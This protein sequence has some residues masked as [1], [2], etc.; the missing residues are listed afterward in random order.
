MKT[1]VLCGVDE[2]AD[3]VMS[4]ATS[5]S[6][7][8]F[9]TA[10]VVGL[11][12]CSPLLAQVETD[13]TRE[14][15]LEL[16]RELREIREQV[17]DR[18]E[19]IESRLAQ[20]ETSPEPLDEPDENDAPLDLEELLEEA[21]ATLS[22]TAPAE[23]NATPPPAAASTLNPRIS[24]IGDFLGAA[25]WNTP[26]PFAPPPLDVREVEI[27]FQSVIDP[28]AR[29]DFYV[30]VPSLEDVGLEE[31]FITF[32]TLPADLLVRLGKVR[33]PFGRENVDHRPE[34]FTVDR[35]DVIRAYF[36]DEGLSE[37]GVTLARLIPNPWDTFMELELDV[38]QGA[39]QESFGGGSVEDLLYNLRFRSYYDLNPRNNLDIG[40]SY[41]NGV[42][43]VV[44]ENRFRSQLFG[45][46]ATYQ[47]R[48]L[49]RGAYR[50]FV[51]QTELMRSRRDTLDGSVDTWGF[52]SFAR[53]QLTRRWYVGAR[54][55]RS[56]EPAY[57]DSER[58]SL[59]SFV[60]FFPS[61]F[62]RFR[63]QYRYSDL[64]EGPSSH[65]LFL[66]WYYLIGTH[67]AHRF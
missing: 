38:L 54:V 40:V 12:L 29:A 13:P 44:R 32:L 18:L 25:S 36:G 26:K 22:P 47:W 28:F 55:D 48:P 11:V 59:S 31:G 63:L 20:L 9:A 41:A 61:E 16:R 42:N 15:L 64:R 6:S 58:R 46:D 65:Q 49:R 50:S 39:N 62:Q 67:G 53:Y 23:Q 52:Y 43:D 60:E 51:W 27:A 4:T 14:L 10:V 1:D 7:R 8:C 19:D 30:S 35:P 2:G 3:A 56:Q 33:V 17:D 21:T 5:R 34:T 66:Q 45:M 57:A 24:V 37:A